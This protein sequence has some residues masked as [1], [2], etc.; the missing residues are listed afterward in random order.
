MSATVTRSITC[1]MHDGSTSSLSCH[2]EQ[3]EIVF[4][5]S[6]GQARVAACS[7]LVAQ[8]WGSEPQWVG[9]ITDAD[10]FFATETVVGVRHVAGLVTLT[11]GRA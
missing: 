6:K 1:P 11:G 8:G 4:D 2:D 5:G 9:R 3:V 10:R 7:S